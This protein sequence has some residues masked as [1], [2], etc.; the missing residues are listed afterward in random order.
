MKL[1][2]SPDRE[3]KDK[4]GRYLAYIDIEDFGSFE[5][6]MLRYGYAREYKYG[7]VYSKYIEY[8]ELER[9]AKDESLGLW[10]KCML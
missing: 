7:K 9:L 10:G 4:Y 6:Y 3:Y 1:S 2:W 5:E 8:R